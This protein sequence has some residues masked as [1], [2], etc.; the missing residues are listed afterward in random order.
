MH[1]TPSLRKG[2]YPN[3]KLLG[4]LLHWMEE[5]KIYCFLF[6]IQ[7]YSFYTSLIY[8]APLHKNVREKHVSNSDS[9]RHGDANSFCRIST[10][11]L[12]TLKKSQGTTRQQTL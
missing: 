1:K 11:T 7:Y 3:I 4:A 12:H 6:A 2:K 9:S 8:S 5:M 10:T